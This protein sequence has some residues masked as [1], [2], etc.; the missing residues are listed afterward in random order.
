ML[1]EE[2]TLHALDEMR[3]LFPDAKAE[4]N[5][6]NAFELVIATLLSAQTTDK[7]VNKVTPALFAAYS[8]PELMAQAEIVDLENK[9]KTLGLYR[10]KAKNMKRSAQMLVDDFNSMIP[11]NR[12][13]LVKLPGV[14]RKTANVVLS[15]AFDVPA[16][17]VDTHVERV[18]KRLKIVEESASVLQ[19]EETLQAKIPED[20][21]SNAH[22]E[23]IFFG[24]YFCTARKPNCEACPLL[25]ICEYGQNSL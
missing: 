12:E 3:R 6:H 5:Y 19:V 18:S 15:V 17:A 1:D 13:D 9:I 21:W 7:Q 23:L 11:S 10:N 14:G 16:I 25:N 20:R 8:T 2:Q 22:H 4:L 24:R